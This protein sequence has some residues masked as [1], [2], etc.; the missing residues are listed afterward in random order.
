MGE[1]N[2]HPLLLPWQGCVPS[3]GLRSQGSLLSSEHSAMSLSQSPSTAKLRAELFETIKTQKN[4]VL[5]H[6]LCTS[7]E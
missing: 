4:L 6:A 7:S 2:E 1:G 5:F 3:W